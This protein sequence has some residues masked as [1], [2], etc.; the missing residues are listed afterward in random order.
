[1]NRFSQIENKVRKRIEARYQT[2]LAHYRTALGF[3][4]WMLYENS[5]K[6]SKAA[7]DYLDEA[8]RHTRIGFDE[9]AVELDEKD[10]KIERLICDIRNNWAYYASERHYMS[11]RHDVFIGVSPQEQDQYLSF[12]NWIE[13]RINNHLENATEYRDSI[14]TVRERFNASDIEAIEDA[15]NKA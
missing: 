14:D 9:H 7:K 12:V 15:K 10:R 4:N 8:I 1:M 3:M 11:K 13:K 2:S 5:P 6:G